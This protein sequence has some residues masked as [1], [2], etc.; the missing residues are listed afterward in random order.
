MKE[1]FGRILLLLCI[2]AVVWFAYTHGPLKHEIYRNE[3]MHL[4]L[5]ALK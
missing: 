3:L 1:W 4:F 2:G 5:A